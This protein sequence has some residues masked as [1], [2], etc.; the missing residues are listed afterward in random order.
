MGWPVDMVVVWLIPQYAGVDGEQDG[1]LRIW[2]T[3]ENGGQR[4][5]G[6]LSRDNSR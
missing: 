3:V 6:E 5:N 2:F 1:Y 4:S